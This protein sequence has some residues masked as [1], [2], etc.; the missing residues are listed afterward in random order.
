MEWKTIDKLNKTGLILVLCKDNCGIFHQLM[1][2]EIKN[3]NREFYVQGELG[4]SHRICEDKIKAA[5]YLDEICSDDIV[6]K[7]CKNKFVIEQSTFE[8]IKDISSFDDIKS[9]KKKLEE[10]Y[11]QKKKEYNNCYKFFWNDKSKTSFIVMM[12]DTYKSETFEI[13]ER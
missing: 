9:A 1:M 11:K 13:V 7:F 2:V 6:S 10:I 12:L 5:I 3:K 8:G 4:C